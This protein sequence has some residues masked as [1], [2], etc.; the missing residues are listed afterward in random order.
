MAACSCRV[1]ESGDV[2]DWGAR[3]AAAAALWDMHSLDVVAD[4]LMHHHA[5]TAH[6]LTSRPH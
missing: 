2:T 3:A 4:H 5:L 1:F 6:L